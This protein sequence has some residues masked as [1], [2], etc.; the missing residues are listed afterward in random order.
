MTAIE[1]LREAIDAIRNIRKMVAA[2]WRSTYPTFFEATKGGR[3]MEFDDVMHRELTIRL[4]EVKAETHI[5]TVDI[6]VGID[7]V[8]GD[9][10]FYGTKGANTRI[11]IISDPDPDSTD[12]A[13]WQLLE[14]E[15]HI[16]GLTLIDQID[17]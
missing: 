4:A 2:E 13:E 5:P 14:A 15:A 16:K 6:H 17:L 1:K 11:Y 3:P 10:K 9:M 8:N 7:R 12:R